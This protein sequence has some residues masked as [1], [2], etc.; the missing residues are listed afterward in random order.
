MRE[1]KAIIRPERLHDVLR[2]LHQTPRLPGV[3]VSYVRGFG[4]RYPRENQ[5]EEFAAVD[6]AK[7]EIVVATEDALAVVA[8][9]EKAAHTGHHGDG[10]IFTVAV[11][12]AVRVRSGERDREAL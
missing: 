1:I 11:E 2:A 7:L 10:K 12:H 9:I 4:R 3:T 8:T 5:G 6:M